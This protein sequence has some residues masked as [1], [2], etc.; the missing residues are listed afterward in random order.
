VTP[1]FGKTG[2]ALSWVARADRLAITPEDLC[3]RFKTEPNR[4]KK[5]WAE[6][7]VVNEKAATAK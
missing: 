3:D 4:I 6:L 5:P 1:V 7:T 2:Y